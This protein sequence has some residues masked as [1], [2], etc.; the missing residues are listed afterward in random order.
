MS[1]YD[2]MVTPVGALFL[3]GSDAG[4]HRVEFMDSAHDLER[5]ADRLVGDAH[6][7]PA[8][9]SEAARPVVAQLGAYFAGERFDFE[10]PL[11]PRGTAFQ[12]EVWNALSAIPPRQT[13]SYGEIAAAIG[14]PRA[15]RAV[16]AANG[17][18][19]IAI[20]VPC[21]RVIGA[22]GS[23]T[24]Y[25]GGLDRKL[26]LLDHERTAAGSVNTQGRFAHA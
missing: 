25:G 21:H 22:N 20:V 16:G 12:R 19:P 10:L 1:W 26:W 3:G 2:V 6:E 23:L 8:R 9:D 13:R 7:A 14:R 4:L 24:G 5:F 17:R 15:S 11:A 18:N